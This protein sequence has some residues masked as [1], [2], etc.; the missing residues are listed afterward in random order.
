[1]RSLRHGGVSR[2]LFFA[3][4]PFRTFTDARL[5]QRALI[6]FCNCS[7]VRAQ[8]LPRAFAR[9]IVMAFERSSFCVM[10][11]T[12][13][14]NRQ[15][16]N[17]Q[18]YGY[19]LC[20]KRFAYTATVAVVCPPMTTPETKW[21]PSALASAQR[22]PDALSVRSASLRN[23]AVNM[24]ADPD[25]L[26]DAADMLY[27]A[28]QEIEHLRREIAAMRQALDAVRSALRGGVQ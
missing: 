24:K 6:A 19:A 16:G 28:S 1:V 11:A 17:P 23:L 9:I 5:G 20:E 14:E 12:V 25:V 8:D 18:N 3:L 22:N 21:T 26:H 27:D 7:G 4:L 10:A 15:R 2:Q 13:A